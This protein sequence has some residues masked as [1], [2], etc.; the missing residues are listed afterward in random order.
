MA[1]PTTEVTSKT[2]EI[3]GLVIFDV[4]LVSD[5]RGYYQEKY[6]KEKL[7]KAGMPNT[8]NVVQSNVSFNKESGVTRGLHSEPWNKYISVVSGK[9][10]A[11]YVDL[12]KGNNFGKVVTVEINP[13]VAIY[14]PIGVANSFQ[15][16]EPNTY[17]LYNVDAYW[18]ADNYDKYCFVN[19]ADKE[20]DIK[21]PIGLD[22][23]IISERDQ[24]HP[25]LSEIK[26]I[27][28]V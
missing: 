18:S 25:Y 27:I 19:L 22:K 24:K 13:N 7:I 16:L 8:F 23:A 11:A 10:F 21:W 1:T 4:T 9:V 3:P 14:L 5:A 6:Q 17:Y 12:R 15:T 2:T 20:L 28:I 26:P